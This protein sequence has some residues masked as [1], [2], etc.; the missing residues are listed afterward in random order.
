MGAEEGGKEAPCE[1]QTL[2]SD[3]D[4]LLSLRSCPRLD[5]REE[6]ALQLLAEICWRRTGLRGRESWKPTAIGGRSPKGLNRAARE[7][8]RQIVLRSNMSKTHNTI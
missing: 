5:L 8:V 2:D 3:A 7:L 6:A 4:M 1:A